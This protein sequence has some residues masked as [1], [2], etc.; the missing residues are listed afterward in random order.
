MKLVRDKLPEI[1]GEDLAVEFGNAHPGA[2]SRLLIAKL[3]EEAGELLCADSRN[4]RL[5]EL[6]DL[7]EVIWAIAE[8]NAI[9]SQEVLLQAMGKREARGGFRDLRTMEVV[10]PEERSQA[11]ESSGTFACR[12]DDRPIGDGPW[13][14]G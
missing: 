3:L 5:K 1:L 9:T 8:L 14:S 10:R 4:G 11:Q 13:Y 2:A 12:D 7:Q 6:G